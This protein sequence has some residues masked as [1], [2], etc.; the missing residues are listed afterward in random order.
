MASPLMTADGIAFELS[1]GLIAGQTYWWWCKFN[2]EFI[3]NHL[4]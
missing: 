2:G 3:D 4:R 1:F